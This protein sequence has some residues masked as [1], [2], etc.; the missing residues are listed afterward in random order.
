MSIEKVKMLKTI[1]FDRECWE[2][3][4]IYPKGDEPLHPIILD[5]IL[6]Q[7]GSVEVL[8]YTKDSVMEKSKLK[9]PLSDNALAE[10]QLK[11][12]EALEKA[13]TERKR[14]EQLLIEK[15]EMMKAVEDLQMRFEALSD[16]VVKFG[17]SFD[18]L[19]KKVTDLEN[20]LNKEKITE[21]I[22][23]LIND[24]RAAIAGMNTRAALTSIIKDTEKE[25]SAPSSKTSGKKVLVRRKVIVKRKK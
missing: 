12:K 4:E 2:V 10:A 7:T 3:G 1:Q 13:E 25:E 16:V 22:A 23:R 5:E 15:R 6:K 19:A 14:A 11:E 21:I 18:S 9:Q 17:D 24:S 20:V 8:S